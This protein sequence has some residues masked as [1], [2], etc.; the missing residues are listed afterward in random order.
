MYREKSS[1][2]TFNNTPIGVMGLKNITQTQ[3]E[4][5]GYIGE[6]D[7]WGKGIGKLM[8]SHATKVATEFNLKKIYLTVLKDNARAIK[9]Y[10]HFGFTENKE[11]NTNDLFYME[12][13]L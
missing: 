2:I 8:L 11:K 3:A 12:L 6:I 13:N 5:W 9:L 7:F 10:E 1:F 4:Y